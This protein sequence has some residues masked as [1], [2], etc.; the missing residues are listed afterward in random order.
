MSYHRIL[1]AFDGS[2]LAEK[3]LRH[4]V[5][6]A[7]RKPGT[8][9]TVVHVRQR[10]V[11][12][13]AAGYG[14]VQPEGLEQEIAAHESALLARIQQWTEPLAYAEIAVLTGLPAPAILAH[15]AARNCDLIVMGSRGLTTLK[16]IML[17]SVSHHVVQRA[18][19]PVLVVK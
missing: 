18:T 17:G 6:L 12:F 2:E 10:P 7:E 11:V 9:L 14:F 15:A 13:G 1:A 16:E 8:H 19:V 3:A 5:D 4:A